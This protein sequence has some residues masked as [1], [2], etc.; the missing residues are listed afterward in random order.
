MRLSPFFF[1]SLDEHPQYRQALAQWKGIKSRLEQARREA[2]QADAAWQ[3]AFGAVRQA[4]DVRA[5]SKDRLY[6]EIRYRH[7]TEAQMQAAR[8][9]AAVSGAAVRRDQA[10]L[11]ELRTNDH[12]LEQEQLRLRYGR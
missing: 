7:C 8:R 9:R 12:H 5:E 2:Y 10:H 4:R 6:G 1:L 11:D 3:A